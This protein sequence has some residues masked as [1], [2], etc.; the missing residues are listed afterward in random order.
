MFVFTQ[1]AQPATV[2]ALGYSALF[3]RRF[4]FLTWREDGSLLKGIPG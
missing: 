4:M 1:F 2:I 3:W